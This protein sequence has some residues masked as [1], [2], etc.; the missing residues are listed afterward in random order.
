[1]S[2]NPG[3]SPSVG[4]LLPSDAYIL[5]RELEDHIIVSVPTTT[6]QSAAL[7]LRKQLESELGKQVVIVT[8]NIN[9]CQV[10]KLKPGE[11]AKVAKRVEAG[12]AQR[13]NL[14]KGLKDF[15]EAL[16]EAD[17]DTDKDTDSGI[18]TSVGEHE[19]ES[20]RCGSGVCSGGSGDLGEGTPASANLR[21]VG[22]NDQDE[23]DPEK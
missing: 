6:S 7:E 23:K 19:P 20:C 3:A 22:G 2:G 13:K 21:L 18:K 14:Q 12:I 5:D 17:K 16:K 1:M 4:R 8:H 11:A 10:R 9:F 15:D